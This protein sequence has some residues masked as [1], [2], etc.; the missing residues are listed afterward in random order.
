MLAGD[1]ENV[2]MGGQTLQP[3]LSVSDEQSIYYCLN[4]AGFVDSHVMMVEVA[5][6][7]E[8]EMDVAELEIYHWYPVVCEKDVSDLGVSNHLLCL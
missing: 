8:D 3:D 1:A 6:E 4:Q 2:S 5:A 7:A